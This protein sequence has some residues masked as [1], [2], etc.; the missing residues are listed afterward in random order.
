MGIGTS[1]GA[2]YK[3]EG[4]YAA[5]QWDKRYDPNDDAMV[6]TPPQVEQNKKLDEAETN[7]FGP[8]LEVDYKTASPHITI[9]DED[10]N[11]GIDIALAFSGGGMK[12]EKVGR[13]ALQY[14]DDIFEGINH[15]EALDKLM[16]KTKDFDYKKVKDG[17][18]TSNGRFVSRE[19]AMEIADKMNQLYDKGIPKN[20]TGLLSEDLMR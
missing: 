15:G 13:A 14:G 16:T 6:V 7:Q 11:K 18:M 8:G 17:F 3:D 2:Y 1:K 4:E 5:S 20:A 9:T 10:I 12:V 19:E